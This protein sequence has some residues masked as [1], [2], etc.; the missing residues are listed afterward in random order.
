MNE[1]A[2]VTSQLDWSEYTI[3]QLEAFL[4]EIPTEIKRKKEET[5]LELLK[6]F[7]E[8]AREVGLTMAEVMGMP[9]K[10]AGSK[11]A[12]KGKGRPA[13]VKYRNPE[14]DDSWTGRGRKPG[15]LVEQLE[16]GKELADFEV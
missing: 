10:A 12:G 8:R 14:T 9:G 2:T 13:S 6:Q 11:K 1:Q 16:A 7:E 4:E 5:R 15:W 3:L